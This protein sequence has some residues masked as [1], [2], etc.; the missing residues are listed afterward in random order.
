MLHGISDLY[1]SREKKINQ[2]AQNKPEVNV[3]ENF[4]IIMSRDNDSKFT[5]QLVF[6][7]L[8][9][10]RSTQMKLYFCAV[11]IMQKRRDQA[12]WRIPY[13]SI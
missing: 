4:V 3:E 12:Q 1:Y 8:Y 9:R 10:L 6:L 2:K 7:T 5:R 13:F 11:F